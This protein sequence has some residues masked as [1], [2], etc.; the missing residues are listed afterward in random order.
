MAIRRNN[1]TRRT[2]PA[3]NAEQNKARSLGQDVPMY[4]YV[5]DSS[6]ATGT[7]CSSG[8]SSYDSGSS[9]S[10]GGSSYSSSSDSGSSSSSCDS[11]GGF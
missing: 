5:D 4:V 7:D 8:S 9:Y 3:T 10:S 6:P 11:G 1:R 2:R